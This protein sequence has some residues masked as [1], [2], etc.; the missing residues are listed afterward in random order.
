MVSAILAI[1]FYFGFAIFVTVGQHKPLIMFASI[2]FTAS[3]LVVLGS[4]LAVS[5]LG[6][7][8]KTQTAREADIPEQPGI[9]HAPKDLRTAPADPTEEL[10]KWK[11][12]LDAGAISQ[13]DYDK[14]KEDILSRY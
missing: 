7:Q 6:I 1:L 8:G 3:F 4:M 10:L 9:T 12:L 14:K 13:D 11:K 5:I 2:F